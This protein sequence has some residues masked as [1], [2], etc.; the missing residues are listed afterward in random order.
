M[1]KD[2]QSAIAVLLARGGSK[3]IPGK[4]LRRVG[5]LSLVARSVL[6]ARDAKRVVAVY[7]STDDEAIGAEARRFGARAIARPAEISGDTATSESGWIHALGVIRNDFPGVEQLA[8]LQ[9]TSPFTTGAEIDACLAALDEKGAACALSVLQDH[10]FLWRS[11]PDEFGRGINHDHTR[12]RLRRQDLE[13]SYRESGAIYAV[14]VHDFERTGQRFCGPIALVPINHPPVE[15]DSEADLTIC[16]L[17]A[18]AQGSD[19]PALHT[20]LRQVRALVMDFDGVHTDDRVHVD[21]NGIESVTV[22]RRDG[23]GLELLRRAGRW[24]LLIL[25]KERNPVVLRRA[26]K[27]KV[28]CL[29]ATDDKVTALAAWLHEHGLCWDEVLFVGNDLNDV[30]ALAR[31]GFSACPRDA[32]QSVLSAVDWVIPETGG[33]GVIRHIADALLSANGIPPEG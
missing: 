24:K 28:E 7:V 27:V 18:R 14:R 21:Q 22:S 1:G 31:A 10:S 11:A 33:S 6:A 30:S 15:V 5:G 9:C 8:L 12:Q 25:S 17:Y 32:N 3:G 4:N 23:L 19:D 16:D 13:P 2:P 26:E 20:K 29:Q